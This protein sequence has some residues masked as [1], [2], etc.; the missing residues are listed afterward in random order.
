MKIRLQ[1]WI[2]ALLLLCCPVQ[3]QIN[4]TAG[5]R[6]SG[7]AYASL[8]TCG[9]GNEFYTTFGHTALR[10]CDSAQGIDVVYNYGMFDFGEPHFYFHFA[11]G[12]LN[13][14]LGRSSFQGFFKEY[15]MEGSS[16]FEQRLLLTHAEVCR[17][18]QLLE[19]NYMPENKHYL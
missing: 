2:T 7:D 18:F 1:I 17:L 5:V 4:E 6:L 19:T 3:A 11:Q 13:Y 9:P 12:R 8:L 10:L 14:F 16:M 15:A